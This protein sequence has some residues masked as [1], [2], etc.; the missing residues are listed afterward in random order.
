MNERAAAYWP[1]AMPRQLE[2]PQTSLWF[3]IEGSAARFPD[4]PAVIF[5]DS[6]LS[7]CELKRGAEHLAGFLQQRCAVQRGDRVALFLHNS[8]QFIV[9]YYAILRAG[10]M[11]VPVNSMSTAA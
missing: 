5:Y 1:Q 11:V 7:Y 2:V 3:N 10:A 6:V 4:K 9:A 8:P